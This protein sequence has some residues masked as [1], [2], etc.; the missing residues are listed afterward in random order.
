[1][2]VRRRRQRQRRNRV[3]RRFNDRSNPLET[4]NEAEVFER[5]RLNLP[6]YLLL[7]FEFVFRFMSFFMV[8]NVLHM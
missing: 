4:L 1:M 3:P 8:I 5:Y 2:A 6:L 7:C